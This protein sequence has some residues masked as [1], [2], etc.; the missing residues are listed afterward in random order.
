[1]ALERSRRVASYTPHVALELVPAVSWLTRSPRGEV[2]V[3]F[4]A[5]HRRIVAAAR[6]TPEAN[7]TIGSGSK[8]A[9]PG[10]E[11]DRRPLL[12][13]RLAKA[14]SG[15]KPSSGPVC[16]NASSFTS[17]ARGTSR[18]SS[19]LSEA[20]FSPE[21]FE[22]RRNRLHHHAVLGRSRRCSPKNS[23]PRARYTAD[24]GV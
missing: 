24:P 7:L 16:A 22:K 8:G 9:E 21:F 6:A 13:C 1:M 3:L 15:R 14:A 23:T 12:S 20:T 19:A 11:A 2:E 17:D 4:G 18:A 5:H 10:V